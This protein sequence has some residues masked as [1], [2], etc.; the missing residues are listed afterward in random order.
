MKE[1]PELG[2]PARSIRDETE[3]NTEYMT[4]LLDLR[5]GNTD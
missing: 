3:L 2:V 1:L 4:S 5:S